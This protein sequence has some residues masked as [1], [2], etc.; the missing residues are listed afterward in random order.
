[1]TEPTAAAPPTSAVHARSDAGPASRAA[2]IAPIL[3]LSSHLR[4]QWRLFIGVVAVVWTV[5]I[6]GILSSVLSVAAAAALVADTGAAPMLL[7]GLIATVIGIGLASWTE[8]WFAH[9]LAYRV[10][11][12]IR[13][14]IHRALARLAPLGLAGRKSGDTVSAAMTDAES[15]EWFY[16]H[17][18]A[19]VVAGAIA[20][21]TVSIGAVIWLGPAG[22]LLPLA[23]IIIV[24]IPIT[25]LPWAVRQG[26]VLRTA[27]STMSAD[28]LSARTGAR[29]AVLLGRLDIVAARAADGTRRIQRARRALAVRGGIEQGLIEASTVGIVLTALGLSVQAVSSGTLAPTMVPVIVTLAAAGVSPA[30]AITGAVGK[31]G[32]TSAA[33]ARVD[34]L[35]TTPGV[36]PQTSP[37]EPEP[38]APRPRCGRTH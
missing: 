8:Q 9:V 2:V 1:M 18:A 33:A 29:E 32:E 27:I 6:L 36:R 12:T 4:G 7:I 23:Q 38:T 25:L 19:Q 31:L 24:A 22:L 26:T 37:D 3:A 34:E 30:V 10:I 11:D 28:A 35:I 16:A 5:L 13:L 21:V 17:T 15:L 20:S 14:R